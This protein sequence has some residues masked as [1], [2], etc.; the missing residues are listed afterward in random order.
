[1]CVCLMSLFRKTKSWYSYVDLPNILKFYWSVE[2]QNPG[3]TDLVLHLRVWDY[4]NQSLNP[5]AATY[6]E[7]FLN[8]SEPSFL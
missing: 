4:K 8:F 6:F 3:P 5:G 2:F 7:K 1:M